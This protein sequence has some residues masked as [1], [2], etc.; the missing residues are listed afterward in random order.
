MVGGET[1]KTRLLSYEEGARG[2]TQ[3]RGA[4]AKVQIQVASSVNASHI[5]EAEIRYEVTDP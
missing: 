3:I 2:E 5:A 4:S 1:N